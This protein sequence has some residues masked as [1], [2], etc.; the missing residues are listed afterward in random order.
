MIDHISLRRQFHEVM[1]SMPK[2]KALPKPKIEDIKSL[3]EAINQGLP[4]DLRSDVWPHLVPNTIGITEKLYS[5]LLSQ[6]KILESV[7]LEDPNGE[8]EE[9][10]RE[11][12]T[13]I[14]KDLNR[15]HP[16]LK[17]FKEGE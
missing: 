2:L 3:E 15:T 4:A 12:Y 6:A 17:L 7:V 10:F 5:R 11:S 14:I 1:G 13:T 8:S 16:Q 9:Y